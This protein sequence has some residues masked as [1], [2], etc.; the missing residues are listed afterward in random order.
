MIVHS[1]WQSSQKAM[2]EDNAMLTG[3]A[4]SIIE[5]SLHFTFVPKL[6]SAAHK[7]HQADRVQMYIHVQM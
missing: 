6:K 5:Q 2:K 1:S 3:I 4:W 7:K